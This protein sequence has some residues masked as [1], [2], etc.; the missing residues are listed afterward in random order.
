[1]NNRWSPRCLRPSM[2][3][4]SL[5]IVLS[6]ASGFAF[7]ETIPEG[8]TELPGELIFVESVP[9]ETDLDL[10]DIPEAR[11]VWPAMIAAARQSLDI[12]TFYFSPRPDGPGALTPVI[13]ALTAAADRG[14]RIRALSDLGFNGTYPETSALIAEL[15]GA[16]SRC[17]D[18]KGLWGGVLH[19][20]CFVVDG[21]EF[22]LGSQNW[23]WRALEH[24]HELGVRVRHPGLTA[25]L[26]RIFN[27]DWRLAAGAQLTMPQAGPDQG[28]TT[29]TLLCRGEPVTA[30]LAASPPQALPAGIPWDEPLLV[31]LAD[32]ASH[33]LRLQLL[34]YNPGARN[35][36]DGEYYATLESALERAA[37]RG[38]QVRIILSNWAKRH[39][40]LPHIQKLAA[41]DNIEIRFTNIPAWSG[42]FVPY[43]R[44]EHA[45]YLVADEAA[46]WI[47]T[48]NW[49]R[50]YFH[51]SRNLSLFLRGNAATR[52][53]IAFFDRSWNSKYAEVVDPD[54]RYEPPRIG[55]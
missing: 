25:Q 33:T 31:A 49:S 8:E 36:A 27:L 40:M 42:G 1:M 52:D 29:F 23:D 41:L 18:A 35:D 45:K 21:T 24:I 51:T 9:L 28:E 34:S 46:C 54:G 3:W 44:V 43:A 47:G 10:A 7:T 16:A 50:S 13:E 14:V 22:F 37:V 32:G 38:V 15:P 17:L 55:E 53:P 4:F 26:V 12:A 20:K 48:A 19:A 2:A 5:G 30:T 6:A 11:D 39:Y